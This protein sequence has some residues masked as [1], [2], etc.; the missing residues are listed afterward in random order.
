MAITVTKN[1]LEAYQPQKPNPGPI[2]TELLE[3]S[4]TPQD[5]QASQDDLD[6]IEDRFKRRAITLTKEQDN[7]LRNQFFFQ[8][9]DW[10]DSR[11]SLR[12][13]LRELN[14]LYEGVVKVTDFPWQGASQL[15]V[16]VPKIKARELK[17]PSTAIQCGPLHFSW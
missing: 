8:L 13:K 5:I 14:D 1:A 17:P 2:E 11:S 15:H 12:S 16:P 4:K 10:K 6:E 9:Q 7:K 3:L